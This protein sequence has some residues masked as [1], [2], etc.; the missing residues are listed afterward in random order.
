MSTSR[1]LWTGLGGNNISFDVPREQL[2]DAVDG[3]LSDPRHD[4]SEIEHRIKTVKLG[5]ADERV[6]PS[7]PVPARIGTC[8]Q[9][10]TPA[11]SDSAQGAL[12]ARVVDF[13]QPIIDIAREGAYR[14]AAAVSDF[15]DSVLSL[16]SSH[17]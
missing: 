14:M 10:V 15:A 1:D 13:Y 7:D 5:A 2:F 8:E 6:D 16:C 12:G 17:R 3:M 9:V 4:L 11:E